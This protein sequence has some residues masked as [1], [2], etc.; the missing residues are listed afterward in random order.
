M[1]FQSSHNSLARFD[2]KIKMKNHFMLYMALTR[3]L[4]PI[5]Y[6]VMSIVMVNRLE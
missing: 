4:S 6:V 2:L 5:N 1:E 3:L